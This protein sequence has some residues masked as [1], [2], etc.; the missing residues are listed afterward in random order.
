[1]RATILMPPAGSV[2]P[3]WNGSPEALD[4]VVAYLLAQR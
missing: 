3:A 2:M 4:R 1:M